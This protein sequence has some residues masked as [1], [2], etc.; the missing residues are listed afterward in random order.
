MNYRESRQILGEIKKAK[1]I[2]VS[3]HKGP[4]PDSI[5]STMALY[6]FLTSIDKEVEVVCLD[7]VADYC[8]F[9]P[10]T[11]V[12]KRV[13]YEKFDFSK[14]DLF[15]IPDSGSWDMVVGKDL[16]KLPK[17]TTIVIDHHIT[18]TGFGNLQIVDTE[19]CAT[20]EIVWRLTKELNISHKYFFQ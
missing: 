10:S 7:D 14:F 3:C 11:E 9:L 18:N 13:N 2:L 20:A 17:V 6:Y 1:K 4:D 8:N 5:G 16:I 19:A 12:I 15:I